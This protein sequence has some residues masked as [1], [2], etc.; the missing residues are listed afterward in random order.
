MDERSN[1][2][3]TVLAL[4][5]IGCGVAAVVA[6]SFPAATRP[7]ADS[8]R[9]RWPVASTLALTSILCAHGART[10]HPST[11]D[12]TLASALNGAWVATCLIALP[13]QDRRLGR[14]L[15]ATTAACDT[16]VGST[17][18]ALRP[19]RKRSR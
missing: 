12:L 11:T 13:Q 18:W 17:Q 2:A 14:I 1:R 16:V 3:R 8:G 9:A 19:R 15:I 7:V 10:P 4:D 6:A 5:A